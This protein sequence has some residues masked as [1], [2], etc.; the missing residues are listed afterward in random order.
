M[1]ISRTSDDGSSPT[2]PTAMAA[3]PWPAPL[4]AP[5]RLA[6]PA[7]GHDGEPDA[8][9]SEHEPNAEQTRRPAPRCRTQERRWPRLV[10]GRRHGFRRRPGRRPRA[11]GTAVRGHARTTPAGR[12]L[13]SVGSRATRGC[14]AEPGV[15]RCRAALPARPDGPQQGRAAARGLRLGSPRLA[16]LRGAAGRTRRQGRPGNGGALV[17]RR[18]VDRTRPGT[19]VIPRGI[20]GGR[21]ARSS[22]HAERGYRH[23]RRLRAG[24][25]RLRSPAPAAV[26]RA[27]VRGRR[28]GPHGTPWRGLPADS[29]R[30]PVA[31]DHDAP[32]AAR[33]DAAPKHEQARAPRPGSGRPGTW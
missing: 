13:G 25:Q 15:A 16:T 10:L 17:V 18:R 22:R 20:V 3:W 14:P 24:P 28:G 4:R 30:K 12:R 19:Q 21:R 1:A 9:R 31:G 6:D 5:S 8:D 32:T 2:H 33:S 27:R 29:T 23:G 7:S 11:G 26:A